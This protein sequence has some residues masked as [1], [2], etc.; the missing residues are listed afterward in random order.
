MQTL[1]RKC[2]TAVRGVLRSGMRIGGSVLMSVLL[3]MAAI[4]AHTVAVE[5][6][7]LVIAM[8]V[9]AGW[10]VCGDKRKM[11]NLADPT[12]DE[13]KVFELAP[14]VVAASTG[15]RRVIE[16]ATLFDVVERVQAFARVRP[17]DGRDDYAEALAKALGT[18]FGRL[19]PERIWPQV[20]EQE[21]RGRSAFTVAIFWV[22][23][24]GLPRWADV[25][26]Y[27]VAGPRY[28]SRSTNDSLATTNRLRP[29][30][31]GNLV[32]IDELQ[33]GY[34]PAFAAE[35]RDPEIRRFLIA[36]YKWREHTAAAAEAFGRRVIELTSARV[37]ELQAT[38]SDVG[39]GADCLRASAPGA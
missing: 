24:G 8:P 15:L 28:T 29:V 4:A 23:K 5:H 10:V 36:P 2:I 13:V 25:D 9:D 38:P 14:K 32:L 7:S 21:R 16:G 27:L 39:P 26:Y 6:G 18:D 3:T 20:I 17:F 37:G 22:T 34:R 19:V 31:L 33:H 12:E 1:P 35:R 30:V 11:S